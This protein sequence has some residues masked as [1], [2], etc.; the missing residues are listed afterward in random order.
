MAS[1][2]ECTISMTDDE[3][4]L[5]SIAPRDDAGDPPVWAD[6]SYEYVLT[7]CGI[8]LTLVED[9]G[10][11]IDTDNDTVTI[12][13]A[14]REYRLP[15]GDYKHG[16]RMTHTATSVTTQWFDGA[17]TVTEGNFE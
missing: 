14:D 4:F 12:G 7:G 13:P 1:A 11:E 9:D 6:Y 5:F 3:T 8:T 16:F 2:Y 15:A 10:V 17:V